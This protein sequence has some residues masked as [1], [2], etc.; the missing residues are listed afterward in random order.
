VPP[1]TCRRCGEPLRPYLRYCTSCGDRLATAPH[2][3][4]GAPGGP[5]G[6]ALGLW[7][8]IQ[9]EPTGLGQAAV[10]FVCC[11]IV[12][13]VAWRPAMEPTRW[14]SAFTPV[15][16]CAH[17]PPNTTTMQVCATQ[18]ALLGYA[19][20]FLVTL[21]LGA[22]LFLLSGLLSR[23][24]QRLTDRL[25]PSTHFLV[26][27][28]VATVLFTISWAGTQ[29]GRPAYP[30]IVP[31]V[32]FPAV[33]GFFAYAVARWGTAAQ[34][35]LDPFMTL[36]D[37]I[38]PLGRLAAVAAV[39]LLVGILLGSSAPPSAA[40]RNA[41]LV[42]LLGLTASYLLLT[43]HLPAVLRRAFMEAAPDRAMAS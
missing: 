24:G 35:R 36:R 6:D 41:Q 17:L 28:V 3:T 34:D 33:V 21:G 38:P 20:P 32:I 13:L 42:V 15:V 2:V 31:Q 37:R 14:L 22:L 43:P 5:A 11:A 25:P 8:A 16:Q 39:P 27:P 19:A 18:N 1:G 40:G 26:V 23:V 4:S 7:A 12:S 9:R 10:V 30:G 29:F